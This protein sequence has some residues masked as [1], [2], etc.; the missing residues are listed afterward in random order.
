M[1]RVL[2]LWITAA[3]GLP[4]YADEPD[5]LRQALTQ[6]RD[7]VTFVDLSRA[8][9]MVNAGEGLMTAGLI[10]LNHAPDLYDPDD[11]EDAAKVAAIFGLV[12]LAVWGVG[13]ALKAGGRLI[14]QN[15][16]GPMLMEGQPGHYMNAEGLNLF[17]AFGLEDQYAYARREPE[18]ERFLIKLNDAYNLVKYYRVRGTAADWYRGVFSA[19]RRVSR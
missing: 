19:P 7:H 5:L 9:R 1:K 2:V 15:Q 16:P 17:M 3:L 4:G 8:G 14:Q 12:S 13:G 18:L 11:D 6:L 10:G